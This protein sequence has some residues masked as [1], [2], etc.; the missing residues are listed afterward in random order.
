M[1]GINL[2]KI[3]FLVLLAACAFPMVSTAH[4]LIAGIMFSLLLGNPWPQRSSNW[5]RK[6]LQLS[7]VG[8]GFGQSLGQV[9]QVGKSSIFYT[10]IGIS[11]TLLV[12]TILG[13]FFR[14]EKNTSTLISFGTAICGGSAIAAMAPVIKAKDD[15]AA[16]ALATVFTL[17]SVALLVFPFFGHLLHLSQQQFGVW[18]GLAIHDTSSVVGAAAAYGSEALAIGTTVKLARAIWIIPFVLG[19]AWLTKSEKKARVPLF[20]IGFVVAAAIRTL[21]PQFG[22]VWTGLA[23][24]SKQ[25]LVI[26]LFLIGAGLTKEILKNVGIRPLAQGVGLWLLASGITLVAILNGM[27]S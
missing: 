9:W 27:I 20:I 5:S 19:A 10:V 12:G 26:T 14:T 22:Q 16:L 7:V 1:V 8:L 3:L 25:A 15:E 13:R 2:K 4:A 24:F 11:L 23:G 18:A 21:L 6:L 17:N